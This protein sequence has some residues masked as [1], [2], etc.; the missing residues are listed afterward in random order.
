M[1]IIFKQGKRKNVMLPTFKNLSHG[2]CFEADEGGFYIKTDSEN[3][4]V[5]LRTGMRFFFFKDDAVK[6][7]SIEVT[8]KDK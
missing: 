2:D 5:C 4:G 6:R 3:E 1:G 8:V 7:I